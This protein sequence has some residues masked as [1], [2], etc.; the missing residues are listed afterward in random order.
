MK[1][2]NQSKNHFI[3]HPTDN[4]KMINLYFNKY[5]NLIKIQIHQYFV[6]FNF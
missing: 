2:L 6:T 5:L 4:F 3:H 1:N